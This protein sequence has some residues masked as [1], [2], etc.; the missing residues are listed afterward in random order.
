MKNILF[1]YT[2]KLI[3]IIL[4]LALLDI[5]IAEDTEATSWLCS[6]AWESTQPH[7]VSFYTVIQNLDEQISKEIGEGQIEVMFLCGADLI[8]RCRGMTSVGKYPVVA[9]GR[10]GYR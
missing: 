8:I 2:K 5:A 9:V 4:R 10:P 6:D 1:F 7:F 3:K